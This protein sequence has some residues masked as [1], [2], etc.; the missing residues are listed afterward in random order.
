MQSHRVPAL[1]ARLAALMCHPSPPSPRL[2]HTLSAAA[3]E[4]FSK[5]ADAIYFHHMPEDSEATLSSA[6]SSSG[7]PAGGAGPAAAAAPGPLPPAG[8]AEDYPL[9]QLWVNQLASSSLRWSELRMVA[10]QEAGA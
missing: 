6:T 10:H 8:V 4:S 7:E 3:V 2:S 9:P 5:L 1:H